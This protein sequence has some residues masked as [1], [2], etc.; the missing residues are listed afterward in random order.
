MPT[1]QDILGMNARNRLFSSLNPASAKS[2][3]TS[4]YATKLLL[5]S[6]EITVPQIY[7]L[8][9][10][11]EDVNYFDWHSLEKDFVIKPTNGSAGKG[12]VAFKTKLA[13]ENK[14]RDALG[15]IWALEDIKLHCFDIIEGQYSTWG[16]QHHIIV[17]ERSLTHPAI[18]KYVSKGT[19]DLRVIVYNQVP[20]MAMLRLPTAQSEGRANLHQGA[21]GVGIDMATGI[22]TY[23]ITGK[24]ESI[25]FLPGTKKKLNGIKIP[26]WKKSLTT[27]VDAASAAQ[28]RYSGVDLFLHPDKGPQ[29]VELN[30]NPGLSIQIANRSGLRRRLERVKDLKVLN[31]EH[32]VRI[33]R[34]LFAEIFADKII[35]EEGLLIVNPHEKIIVLSE[36]GEKIEVP[37]LMH[38]GR[39]R[40]AMSKKLAQ[41]LGLL[42]LDDLLWFQQEK[43]ED[44]AP[45][46]EST[47]IIKDRKLKTTM[48]ISQRLDKT[49]HKIEI[50]RRDLAGM[51]VGENQ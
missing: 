36:A 47:V 2:F 8:L 10:T 46:V 51:L 44:I 15:H 20:V 25:Q 16:A 49:K 4:K 30:A 37:A 31:S 7:G 39:Y 38:T 23:A 17:E 24:G 27:A 35:S 9:A 19:P 33:G 26:F 32:G 48:V 12:I 28:L 1:A 11:Q 45:V 14:W 22:S 21:I 29:V 6:K 3:A 5:D 50:G 40:S 18:A 34:A 41:N 42:D 43:K 13:G